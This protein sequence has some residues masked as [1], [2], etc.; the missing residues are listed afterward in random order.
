[1]PDLFGSRV[2]VDLEE[3]DR[4]EDHARR[5]KPALQSVLRPERFLYGVK[6]TVRRQAF[7]GRHVGAVSLNGKARARLD[8]EVVDEHR[9]GATLARVAPDLGARQPNNFSDEM[10]E[11]K[12][13][14][15]VVLM[16]TTVDRNSDGCFHIAI[17]F[18]LRRSR[19]NSR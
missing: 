4:R 13:R 7:N 9:A 15:D 2:G 6:R 1:L 3:R 16:A 11:E 14:L 8:G 19:E 12:T 18:V 17:P 10:D 5:T